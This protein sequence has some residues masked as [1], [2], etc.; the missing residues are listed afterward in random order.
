MATH[1]IYGRP[2]ARLSELKAGDVVIIDA[3]FDCMAR[4]SERVVQLN[5]AATVDDR[6]WIPCRSGQHALAGQMDG[7]ADTLVGIYRKEGFVRRTGEGW[8]RRMAAAA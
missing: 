6:L 4:W 5:D 3:G 7:E 8:R 2:Y 1:D